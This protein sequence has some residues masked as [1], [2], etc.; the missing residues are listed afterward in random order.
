MNKYE[1]LMKQCIK[2][3]K[4]GQ[5][6]TSPNPLVGCVIVNNKGETVSDG[7]HEKYG[8][9]HAE[10]NA[11]NKCENAKNCTLVVNL[12]PCCHQGKTPPCTDIIIEKGI[13][14]VV[15]GMKDPN[16]IVS[17]KGIQILKNAGI[18]VEG[19]VLEDECRKLNEIF[20]KNKTQNLPF[21]AIKTAATIDGKIATSNG[22]SK[23]ITSE[24][25]RKQVYKMRKQYDAI[26]TS[27]T[28]IIA[29]NPTMKHS[30]KI[31]LDR[32]LKTDFEN[33][34]IYKQGEI[35]VFYDEN[36]PL[37]GISKFRNAQ[38]E[39]QPSPSRGE[40]NIRLIP[41]PT[42]N[43]KLNIDYILE[44]AFEL[45]I[46]SIFVEA[47]GGVNESFLPYTDKLYHFIAP[48]VL[49][50]NTGKSCFYGENRN[51]IS[52]CTNL[53]FESSKV[54][55]PDILITYTKKITIC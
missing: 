4:K 55:S 48:K 42:Q 33:S 22:D 16:P 17:G 9:F 27:S 7:F 47:G 35:F 23:W 11:L 19:P 1:T 38:F 6:K 45:G 43:N 39:I 44:K 36:I 52:E 18:D 3:A 28:T 31:I 29:D 50:D 54:Y 12:E 41:C 26:L 5:G 53:K 15:Y 10:R 51:L 34:E 49:G 40:D 21:I 20:I 24:K 8:E 14:K 25:A 13:K 46:M 2:L 32:E 30:K 37:S